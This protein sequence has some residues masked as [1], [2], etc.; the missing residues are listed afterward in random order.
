M[1][2]PTRKEKVLDLCYWNINDAYSARV[3]SPLGSADHNIVFL[4]PQYRQRLKRE[5][6]AT[7]SI[8]QWS[9][10]A[11]ARL[12][13]SL[14]CTD[15][16]IF[17]GDLNVRT[18]I[19][20]DYIKFCMATTIPVVTVKKYPNSRPWMTHQIKL[21]LR[22]KQQE[23]HRKYWLT[24]RD[25]NRSVK[26]D[27]KK[28]NTLYLAYKD[29]L[30]Q[31]FSSMNTRQAFQK[32]RTHTGTT[33]KVKVPILVDSHSFTR[34]LNHF[35]ARFD[36]LNYTSECERLLRSLPTP[37]Q[38]HFVPFTVDDAYQQLRRCKT[39]KAPGPDEITI[40]CL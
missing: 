2:I 5:K 38:S 8:N 15:W 10:D 6:P 29:K 14:A 26:N 31:D 30:E 36:N 34:D 28:A 12:Q 22:E 39:G 18:E 19:I 27:I 21:K 11:T 13:G 16:S 24:L 1:D 25:I 20:T 7:Y 32:V 33:S 17:G 4:L 23:F 40:V 9:K 35:Y 37:E 3:Q